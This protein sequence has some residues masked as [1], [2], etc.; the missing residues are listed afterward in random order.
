MVLICVCIIGLIIYYVP[1]DTQV[2]TY[3]IH[4]SPM[5]H[6]K[7]LTDKNHTIWKIY[8]GSMSGLGN[9]MFEYASLYGIAKRAG[10]QPMFVTLKGNYEGFIKMF[11]HL[12]IPIEKT[13]PEELEL[14][15]NEAQPNT[16]DIKFN[17][18]PATDLA[19]GTW[20]ESWKYFMPEFKCELEQHFQIAINLKQQAND[21]IVN[22][23]NQW[24]MKQ[25][26]LTSKPSKLTYVGIHIRRGDKAT[27]TQGWRLPM[28]NYFIKTAQFFRGHFQNCVFVVASEN[29]TYA[30]THFQRMID[31]VFIEGDALLDLATLAA[32]NHTIMSVGTFSW[33]AAWLAGG[34]TVYYKDHVKP[35]SDY[36]NLFGDGDYFLPSWI[37]MTD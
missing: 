10:R 4:G 27:N 37:P 34:T 13:F 22:L 25:K 7:T 31:F 3:K 32:C 17:T 16:F 20:L 9:I 8:L 26:G 5:S 14:A 29:V 35:G 6:N 28:P 12:G 15:L 18:L 36:A 11:P 2:M 1:L 30:K 24:C 33:W 21:K 23:T 19:I